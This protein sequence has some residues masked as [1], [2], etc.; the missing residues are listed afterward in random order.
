MENKT[1][2]IEIGELL[3]ECVL[4]PTGMTEYGTSLAEVSA[5]KTAMPP[6]GIRVDGYFEGATIGE[7]IKGILTGVDYMWIRP[8][9]RIELDIHAE[10]TTEDGQKISLKGDGVC[11]PRKG[12]IIS[13]LKE[14]LTLFSSY[15]NYTWLNT[16]QVWAIGTIDL[17]TQIITLKCYSA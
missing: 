2:K 7:K 5:G 14:N 10:I 11:I 8:D 17:S 4:N 12:I 15:K 6:E 16:I 9:G 3:Y 13:D 1:S